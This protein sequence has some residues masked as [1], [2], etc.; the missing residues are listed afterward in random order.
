MAASA[1]FSHCTRRRRDPGLNSI[2][3]AHPV[4]IPAMDITGD[5]IIIYFRKWTKYLLCFV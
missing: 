2:G 5:Y 3:N 1:S 4:G